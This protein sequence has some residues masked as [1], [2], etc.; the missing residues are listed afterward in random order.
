MKL[1]KQPIVLNWCSCIAFGY[2]CHTCRC[3]EHQ[4]KC[5]SLSLVGEQCWESVYKTTNW[6]LLITLIS[7][8]TLLSHACVECL[9]AYV[10]VFLWE[11]LSGTFASFLVTRSID[12]PVDSFLM[13]LFHVHIVQIRFFPWGGLRWGGLHFVSEGLTNAFKKRR[14]NETAAW[15]KFF[16]LFL[17]I[18]GTSKWTP[19]CAELW[20][21]FFGSCVF[22]WIQ[23]LEQLQ[24]S[25]AW[26]LILH[27]WI[28]AAH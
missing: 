2:I 3:V 9:C 10:I 22:V 19:P 25:V 12:K 8:W 27:S 1:S 4:T 24:R 21:M 13:P 11:R 26:R 23:T 28:F 16:I 17:F 18:F 6:L 14:Q 7:M 15:A 5:S 20:R